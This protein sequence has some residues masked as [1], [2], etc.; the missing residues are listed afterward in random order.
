M[1]DTNNSEIKV[2]TIPID[3]RL[4]VESLKAVIMNFDNDSIN[5]YDEM[6]YSLYGKILIFIH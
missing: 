5:D 1:I 3:E 4:G 6:V 2:V